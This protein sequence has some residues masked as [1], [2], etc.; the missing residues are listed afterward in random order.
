MTP[1]AS[2]PLLEARHL[3]K[4]YDGRLAVEDVG[5]ELNRGE[6]LGLLGPNGAGKSTT[7]LMLAGLLKLD[8]GQVKIDGEICQPGSRAFKFQLGVAPQDLAIYPELSALDNLRFFG[9]LYGLRGKELETRCQEVLKQIGLNERAND[10]P[11]N[12]SGGMKRRL[13]FGISILHR[14]AILILDEPTVGVD[15][16]SRAHLLDCVKQLAADGVGVI[17][18]SHYME[19]IEA[20]CQRVVIIDEGQMMAYDTVSNLLARLPSGL[21]LVVSGSPKLNGQ[22]N[23]LATTNTVDGQTTVV[24]SGEPSDVNQRLPI[25]LERLKTAGATL[26]RIES[27]QPNLE[28]LFLQLTGRKLRD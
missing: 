8:G 27:R 9:K 13:N 23:G 26:E 11:R 16:Q 3:R 14:P 7:M 1:A 20:V 6:V 19:E 10:P 12:Y 24:L 2:M 15:P 17:Y 21:N 18:A 4:S 5:F 22:L 25:V 28:H